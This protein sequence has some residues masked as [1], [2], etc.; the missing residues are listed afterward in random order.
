MKHASYV[1]LHLYGSKKPENHTFVYICQQ[2]CDMLRS[3]GMEQFHI[4]LGDTVKGSE[5]VYRSYNSA[6]LLLQSSF[7]APYGSIYTPYEEGSAVSST[8][9]HQF[10]DRFSQTLAA[11]DQSAVLAIC[12]EL[13]Q[14][15]RGNRNLLPNQARDLYYKLFMMLSKQQYEAKISTP[16][17]S[18]AQSPLEQ[19]N[20][21]GSLD[22]LHI[23]LCNAVTQYFE[24]LNTAVPDS[25][26]LFLIKDYI[27][28]NYSDSSLSIK[29]ISEHV[30][31]SS[32]YLCTVFKTETGQT[33]N[34][35]LTNFRI[36]KAKQMLS[37][38]RNKVNEIAAQVGYCDCNYFGKTFKKVVG[39]SPSEYR[40]KEFL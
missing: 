4:I 11:K 8:W 29:D 15:L 13:L 35:Y 7:F 39:L 19:I 27:S 18:P 17:D 1:I 10:P 30:H 16:T 28:S 26:T 3:R 23:L 22:E 24:M 36:E 2:I 31:L 37:D 32:S 14:T 20:G 5:H 21:C 25:S 6:V 40:E 9:L 33:L 12:E 34:Q 38:P